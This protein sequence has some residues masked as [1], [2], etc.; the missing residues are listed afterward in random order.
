[1]DVALSF[2]QIAGQADERQKVIRHQGNARK[3]YDAGLR[4]ITVANVTRFDREILQLK[5]L[6]LK[7]ALLALGES[8]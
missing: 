7:S 4:F 5:L 3:G 2:A 6:A 8:F 1:L